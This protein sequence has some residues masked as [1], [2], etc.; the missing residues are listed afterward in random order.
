MNVR[1]VVVLSEVAADLNAGKAFY[2]RSEPGIGDTFWES[3]CADI[4]SL[5]IYAGIHNRK[6][7]LYRMLAKRF[8]YAIY[9]EVADD[10]AYVVAVLPMRRCPA[11]IKRHLEDRS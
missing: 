4:E 10:I 11:W 8:P 6:H 2:D 1:D 3:L 5:T 7:G 9:Y